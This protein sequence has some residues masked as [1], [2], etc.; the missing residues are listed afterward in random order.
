MLIAY[1]GLKASFAF[2][3]VM[4]PSSVTLKRCHSVAAVCVAW[5]FTLLQ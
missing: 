3:Q 1:R 4:A 5:I 2:N